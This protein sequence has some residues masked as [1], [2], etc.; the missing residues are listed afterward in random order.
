MSRKT[1]AKICYIL[2]WVII[3]LMALSGIIGFFGAWIIGSKTFGGGKGFLIGLLILIYA[4]LMG[5]MGSLGYFALSGVVEAL[6]DQ[7]NVQQGILRNI[8]DIK[9]NMNT[10]IV[11]DSAKLTPA[12][13]SEPIFDN[14]ETITEPPAPTV[15]ETNEVPAEAP[16]PENADIQNPQPVEATTTETAEAPKPESTDIPNPSPVEAP[17]AEQP[18]ASVADVIEPFKEDSIEA[19]MD[20]PTEV[21]EM[22][23]TILTSELKAPSY[24]P[25]ET[26]QTDKSWV[27]AMCGRENEMGS[28]CIACGSKKIEKL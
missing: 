13:V 23:T 2:G 24:I 26:Y 3:S 12:P 6:D 8:M 28:F 7:L 21:A 27:C 9:N 15:Q 19:L 4:A 10:N 11:T 1:V 17:K 16:K 22:D 5:V 14:A 18:A 20:T 25:N